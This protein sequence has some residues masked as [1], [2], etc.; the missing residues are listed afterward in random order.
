M[1]V[2]VAHSH[3]GTVAAQTIARRSPMIRGECRVKA[4]VCLATPFAYLSS[5]GNARDHLLFFGALGSAITALAAGV[6]FPIWG[7]ESEFNSWATVILAVLGPAIFGGVFRLFQSPAFADIGFPAI[8]PSV[9][10]FIIRATRDEAALTIGLTQSIHAISRSIYQAVEDAH[11]SRAR[12]SS[13]VFHATF[14]IIGICIA[15]WLAGH[16]LLDR[17]QNS[18]LIITFSYGAASFI[19]LGS[20]ALV[21]LSVGFNDVRKWPATVEVDA[22]P[23][24]KECSFKSYSD[25]AGIER[26]SLRHGIYDLPAV[27]QEISSI[28]QAIAHGAMPKLSAEAPDTIYGADSQWIVSAS[29]SK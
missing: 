18:V 11:S 15:G 4:L 16:H 23:P 13:W 29:S 27:Q 24:N 6:Y 19:Y 28:I 7:N 3:G 10:M 12:F 2:I 17:W 9:A 8:H 25:V 26:T 22:A 5:L 14:L 20:Y 21:A 1:H